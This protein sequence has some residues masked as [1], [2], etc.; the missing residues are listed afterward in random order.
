MY[1]LLLPGLHIK[2]WVM[3][4]LLGMLVFGI[5]FS[6]AVSLQNALF[7]F[8]WFVWFRLT[9]QAL[10]E[11][12][13]IFI[14][15]VIGIGGIALVAW[16]MKMLISAFTAITNPNATSM[17]LLYELLEQ[18]Q[19]TPKPSVV[20]I[21]G[22]TGLSTLLRGL[23]AY[24]LDLTAIVTVSDDG[25]S[26][27]RLRGAL[28]MPPPGDIRNCLVALAEA[29][30]M[31]ESLFQYRFSNASEELKGHPLGNLIIAGMLEMTGNFRK[32]IQQVSRVLAVRGTVL[33]TTAKAV[34]LKATMTDGSIVRG[35]TAIVAHSGTIA[36]LRVEPADTQPLPEVLE[37]IR[38]ADVII[39]G[40]GSVY[41]SLLPNLIIN[42]MADALRDSQAIKIFVCNVMTQPGESESF[43]AAQH[44]EVVL[45]QMGGNNPFNYTIVNL[46]RP[47]EHVK[48]E[49][50]SK[51]QQY[52]EPDLASLRALGVTPITG[53]LLTE[54]HVARHDPEKLA[55]VILTQV[56]RDKSW[57]SVLRR[58]K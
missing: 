7:A 9:H 42:G 20:G 53:N 41:T 12:A 52:V 6:L 32:A 24:P 48:S 35:E 36:K 19:A 10:S 1:R 45:Q 57:P 3:L 11:N 56:A 40:P 29:E 34:I 17:Q 26:S 55:Q 18:R 38:T 51:G 33:P 49:Y 23:K 43:T 28:D 31:M 39:V 21:G 15:M 8:M 4:I 44:L 16:G 5:G 25:G 47:P 30:P 50:D 58:R 46:Q 37:A 14:G 2:R 22:G 54:D 13:P 27:G